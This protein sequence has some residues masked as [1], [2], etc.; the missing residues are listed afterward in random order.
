MA[1]EVLETGR[2]EA[3]QAFTEY[4][5]RV[6]EFNANIQQHSKRKQQLHDELRYKIHCCLFLVMPIMLAYHLHLPHVC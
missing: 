1:R 3:Q 6:A 5:D 4:E 2:I